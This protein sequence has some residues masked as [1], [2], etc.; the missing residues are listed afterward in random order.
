MSVVSRPQPSPRRLTFQASVGLVNLVDSLDH[1]Y[2]H[3]MLKLLE[4][5]E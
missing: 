5:Y 1:I 3:K 2:R 4:Q